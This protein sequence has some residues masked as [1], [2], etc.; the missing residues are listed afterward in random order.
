MIT[1]P[2]PEAQANYFKKE[3]VKELRLVDKKINSTDNIEKKNYFFSAAHGI[4]SRTF[5]YSFSRDVLLADFVLQTA[6]GL[7]GERLQRIKQGDSTV[8]V[9]NEHFLLIGKGLRILADN[10]EKQENIQ[11]AIELI[12]TTAFSTTGP[13]NYLVEKGELKL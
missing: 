8:N 1:L 10:F 6:Y 2:L 3:L 13:G 5:R 9:T 11:N 12:L 7:I 4:T